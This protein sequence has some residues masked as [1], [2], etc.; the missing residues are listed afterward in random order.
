LKRFDRK[1]AGAV[2]LSVREVEMLDLR[3]VTLKHYLS[4]IDRLAPTAEAK[5]R[6]TYGQMHSFIE[7]TALMVYVANTSK[8]NKIT[9][10]P[11]EIVQYIEG[12]AKELESTDGRKQ[13]DAIIMLERYNK[14]NIEYWRYKKD[15]RELDLPY[16]KF[17]PCMWYLDALRFLQGFDME[18]YPLMASWTEFFLVLPLM[19]QEGQKLNLKFADYSRMVERGA[20]DRW[21]RENKGYGEKMSGLMSTSFKVMYVEELMS[22]NTKELEEEYY[23]CHWGNRL[24]KVEMGRRGK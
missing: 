3:E 15:H 9:F 23:K 19:A 12:R 11:G 5:I 17:E 8:A 20:L 13:V 18:E 10:D 6:T 21:Y 2:V 4:N 24:V 16:V 1:F 14:M 22:M 7:C